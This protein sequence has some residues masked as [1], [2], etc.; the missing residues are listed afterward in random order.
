MTD[1]STTAIPELQAEG[2]DWFERA[3]APLK[4]KRE[5][6]TGLTQEDFEAHFQSLFSSPSGKV[7]LGYLASYVQSMPGF[8]PKLAT[9]A[10]M[11]GLNG[12]YRQG[13]QDLVQ[14]IY[15]LST[16]NQKNRAKG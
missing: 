6:E 2:W 5:E 1:H 16:V 10:D 8:D 13:M 3:N 12:C 15:S 14:H 11:V 4:T 9:S 7:V